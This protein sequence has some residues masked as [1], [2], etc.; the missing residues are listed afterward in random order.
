[1]ATL[2]LVKHSLPE[3]DPARIRELTRIFRTAERSTLGGNP[4]PIEAC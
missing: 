1:M 3:I 4:T 2:V